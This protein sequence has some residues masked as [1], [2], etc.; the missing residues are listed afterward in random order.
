MTNVVDITDQTVVIPGTGFSQTRA[1]LDSLVSLE[2]NV[3][4]T[5][6]GTTGNLKTNAF[7]ANV[8][9]HVIGLN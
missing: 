4:T 2:A 3:R 6:A 8:W 1:T 9:P 5:S 7:P